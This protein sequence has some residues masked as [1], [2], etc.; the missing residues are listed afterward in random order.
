[1]SDV[2]PGPKSR[3]RQLDRLV[4]V[5]L[6]ASSAALLYV[7]R[8]YGLLISDDGFSV[9]PV[10]RMLEG[11]LLYRDI[12]HYYAPLSYHL[13]EIV[14]TLT[15]PSLL[16]ART[17]W[18]LFLLGSIAGSYRIARRFAPPATAWLPAATYALVP[19]PWHKAFYGLCIVSFLLALARALERSSPARHLQLGAVCGVVL[20]VRQELGLAQFLVAAAIVGIVPVWPL[21]WQ[22]LDRTAVA[23]GMRRVLLVCTGLAVAVAPVF[24][25][26]AAHENLGNLIDAV[27]RQAVQYSSRPPMS[28][29]RF[30]LP[31]G[32][33]NAAEGAGVGALLLVPL[34]FGPL[35][36][37]FLVR[38]IRARGLDV[39]NALAAALVVLLV[40]AAAQSFNPPLLVRFLQSA[41][42]FYLLIPFVLGEL[43]QRTRGPATLFAG[44][45]LAFGVVFV[46]GG[47]QQVLPSDAYIGSM[48]SL[49]YSAPVQVMGDEF[50]TDES[51]ANEIRLVQAFIAEHTQPDEPIFTAPLH[52]TYYLLLDRPNPTAYLGDFPGLNL[53]MSGQRKRTEMQRLLAS[54]ARYAVVDRAWWAAWFGR[55][56][57][58]RSAV[59]A[60][61]VPVRLYGA[62]AILERD[63]SSERLGMRKIARR[64]W[65]HRT[66]PGDADALRKILRNWP[67]EPVPHELLGELLF[68]QRKFRA[69][70]ASLEAASRLDPANPRL[71]VQLN[72]ARNQ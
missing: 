12:Y 42:C 34:A 14:F 25:Y 35:A 45:S 7:L 63:S 66:R 11:G 48:R 33:G 39:R 55:T 32:F 54:E 57:P 6:V 16:S 13:L 3:E 60:A 61:F 58:I 49:R 53:A 27:F 38:A 19:G 71:Q 10:V 72:R 24:A 47:P 36:A 37:G 64:I 50:F 22:N 43:S 46:I 30:V 5:V 1:M 51:L 9:Y 70:A 59:F 26:Y 2:K 41:I 21:R 15:G 8:P 67:Y 4:L 65:Q 20:M 69:A 52:S 18:M 31:G 17:L 56:T 44:L 29:L 40:P 23:T 68:E 62:V 28:F